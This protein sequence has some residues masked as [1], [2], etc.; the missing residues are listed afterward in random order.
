MNGHR[1]TPMCDFDENAVH[2]EGNVRAQ[3]LP[4][5]GDTSAVGTVNVFPMA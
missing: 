2:I 4:G 1:T 5:E 3:A